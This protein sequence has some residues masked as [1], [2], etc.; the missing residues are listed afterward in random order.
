MEK[1]LIKF[2]NENRKFIVFYLL[3]AFLHLILLFNGG[4]GT[5]GFWPFVED[6]DIYDYNLFEFFIYMTVPLLIFIIN[7]IAGKD[8]KKFFEDSNY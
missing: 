2:V 1:K 4:N 7:K 8:I 3:W 6:I 5:G